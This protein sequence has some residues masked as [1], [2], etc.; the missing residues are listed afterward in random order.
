LARG[1][2]RPPPFA[3][4]RVL[5]AALAV[6]VPVT[7]L[8]VAGIVLNRAT[9]AFARVESYAGPIV[10]AARESGIDPPL[11]AAVVYVE[12][13]GKAGAR[14]SAGAIG[15]GQLKPAAADE[16]RR[17]L[18][19]TPGNGGRAPVSGDLLDPAANLRLAAAYLGMLLERF[20]DAD[21]ALAA[22]A[23]GPGAADVRLRG[24]GG[25][26]AEAKRRMFAV[27]GRA[28]EYVRKVRSF[29]GRF[30]DRGFPPA[31]RAPAR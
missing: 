28:G 9:S 21:L 15:L 6:L 12:S 24:A 7:V 25:D 3:D 17:R 22:Y 10:A 11:L 4:R 14:S 31:S 27:A 2:D 26:R 16:A 23:E 19:R 1:S 29:E 30:R 8:F 13:R 18:E 20:G 5:G